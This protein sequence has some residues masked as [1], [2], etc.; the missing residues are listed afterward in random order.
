MGSTGG[1]WSSAE[2]MSH[3]RNLALVALRDGKLA[4]AERDLLNYLARKWGL[5]DAQV[6]EV[7]AHP[8]RVKLSIPRD[9][10]SRFQQLYDLV[11]MMIIDGVLGAQ[12]KALCVSFAM[13]LGMDSGLIP[14]IVEEIVAGDQ[15]LRSEEQIQ[16]AVRVRMAKAKKSG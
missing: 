4:G 9:E 14:V 13:A 5:S 7:L 10:P 6:E 3:F 11:D 16:A 15:L 1:K 8:D 12:E 2:K